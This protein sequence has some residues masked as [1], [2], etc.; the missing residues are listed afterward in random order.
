[1]GKTTIAW[2]DY[3]HNYWIGCTKVAPPC[4]NCYAATLSERYGWAKWGVGMPRKLTS[5]SNRKKPH[6]WN[7]AAA[8]A[9][10]R[11][12]VFSASL[13]DWLDNEVPNEWRG[14]LCMTVE[15]TPNLDW[16]LLTKRIGNF[17]KLAPWNELNIPDNVWLGITCGDQKE[18]DRDW[19]KL[20]ELPAR[21][22]FISYEPA[23]GPLK[24][25]HLEQ[26][27]EWII[28]GGESG[29]K[30]RGMPL[31]WAR[32]LRDE[33][34][35][36]GVSFFFKQVSALKPDDTMIPNDLTIRQFPLQN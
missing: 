10:V 14:G 17:K 27:P 21:V 29:S 15:D 8:K 33:C 22:R 7:R 19:P 13:S 31:E 28:C 1:M 9:G 11:Y 20:A 32:A 3:T 6:S 12:K 18:Y 5:E 16:L 25:G 35:E 26:K 34:A 23:L 24:I 30:H 2:T 36:L 4:D